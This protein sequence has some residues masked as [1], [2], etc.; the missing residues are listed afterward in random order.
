MTTALSR[1]TPGS[2]SR[3]GLLALG[4]AGAVGVLLAGA[5]T[6]RAAADSATDRLC[7]LERAY[8]ARVG[9]FAYNVATGVAVRH[10]AD[11]RFPML[12][13][14]KTLA[15]AAVLRDLDRH[16]EVLGK[17]IH[18]TKAD[19]VSDSPVTDTPEHIASGLSVARLCDA[20]IGDSDNTAGNLL[21]RE[22][23]GP[24]AVT[25]FARSLGDR[26]TRLD[27]WE[28]ELNSAEPGRVTDTTTPFAIGRDYARL[29]LG[30]ALGRRDRARLTRW[31]LDCRTSGTRFRAG[32][33]PEWTVADKTG[34]GAYGS[35]NDVGIAWTPEG[36]PVVLAVLTT[37]PGDP[38]AAGDHQLIRTTAA[39]LAAA[40]AG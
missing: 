40:V 19:C 38:E 11:E 18:Y 16:G 24:D 13:T 14:F 3:R 32:L 15:A 27:R 4:G 1:L 31:L 35:C 25:R 7:A 30:K 21:L 39:V 17:V 2:P 9:A 37:K 6:A 20:A 36:T 10:R 12:S 5:G 28:P 34:G 26:T 22:L 29:V 23:G 8:G 33:P